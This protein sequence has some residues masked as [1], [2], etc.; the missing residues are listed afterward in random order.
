MA[1]NP[2]SSAGATCF[3]NTIREFDIEPHAIIET[4]S[5]TK[6]IPK[7]NFKYPSLKYRFVIPAKAGIHYSERWIPARC[8]RE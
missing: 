3:G 8:M 2:S 1:A 6:V 5:Y 7:K 4:N